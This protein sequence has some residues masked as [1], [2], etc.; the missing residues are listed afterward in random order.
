MNQQAN[1]PLDARARAEAHHREW[2]QVLISLR[3]AKKSGRPCPR[4]IQEAPR[5]HHSCC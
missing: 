2:S 1:P 3:D 5:S 4:R